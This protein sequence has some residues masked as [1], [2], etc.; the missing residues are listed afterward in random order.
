M[1][2]LLPKLDFVFSVY[3]SHKSCLVFVA[4]PLFPLELFKGFPLLVDFGALR[5]T[6]WR[7]QNQPCFGSSNWNSNLDLSS[8]VFGSE[9]DFWS[10]RVRVAKVKAMSATAVNDN[11]RPISEYWRLPGQSSFRGF[12]ATQFEKFT[13]C[14]LETWTFQKSPEN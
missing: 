6:L 3:L 13:G 10:S 9:L 11:R 7:S 12:E 2:D 1:K 14:F 8:V 5:L 4:R